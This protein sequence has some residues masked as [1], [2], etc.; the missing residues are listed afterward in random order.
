MGKH[1]AM[2]QFLL[3]WEGRDKPYAGEADDEGFWTARSF[4]NERG[5][6]VTLTVM[7]GTSKEQ[8]IVVYPR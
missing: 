7:P 4:A 1:A 5:V 2:R 8:K 6:P 3:E